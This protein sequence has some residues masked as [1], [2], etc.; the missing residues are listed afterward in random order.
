M[1]GKCKRFDRKN[2]KVL[3]RV[4]YILFEMGFLYIFRRF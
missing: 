1:S 3:Q 4:M 2:N